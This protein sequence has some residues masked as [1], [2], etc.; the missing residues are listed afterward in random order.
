MPPETTDY[1]LRRGVLS[2][3][4]ILAQS[5]STISPT[6]TPVATIPLVCALAGNGTWLA[7]VLA[8]CA[9]LLVALCVSKFAKYSASPGSLYS[10][11]ATALPPSLGAITAWSLLLAYVA[12][13]SS[14]IGGFYHYGNLLLHDATGHGTSAV[15]LS[16]VVTGIS[17]WIAWRDVK[18]SARLMLWIEVVSV[19]LILLVVALVLVRHGWHID[20]E[21]LHLR[22]MTGSG[23]RLG[24]VL[25]LFSFC[26]FESATT[27]GSEAR[28]PLKT[29]P[30]AVIQ[31]A[32]LSG[33]IFTICAYTEDLGL[34]L[35]GQDLG[36][37]SAPMRVLAEV[38]GVRML[39]ELIDIG[40]L[41]S[42]FACTLA[43]ITAAARV[44]LLMSHH[45]LAHGSMRTT[46]ARNE[47][48]SR[49]VIATGIAAVLPVAILAARGADGLDVYGWMGSLATYG[50]IV[51]YA[52]VCS[53][54]PRYLRRHGAFRAGAQVVPWLACG[55]M[56]LA[57][58][59]NLYP[60]PEGPYGK[61]P[62]VYLAYL[63]AGLVWFFWN[64]KSRE[65]ALAEGP[66]S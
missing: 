21:Q 46:H 37:S 44:L 13:G 57:L 49:A 10:Y 23:L 59:G 48:P 40:A 17:M 43:C 61:L 11:A 38:G 35:A 6:A 55:A 66:E 60:V 16:L 15:V 34:R 3:I 29:I 54:L 4:E 45:G 22:G 51:A 56:L 5:V 9:V 20:A 39:G 30:R 8:T 12:T 32:L 64:R 63:A 19:S 28:D 52:L 41:V 50:F 36:T 2:P 62:Y 1:G 53:V 47:T 27:L 26:G 25:A 42:L 65:A 58:V 31:S 14:V 7:Y 24:L 33:A 18:I